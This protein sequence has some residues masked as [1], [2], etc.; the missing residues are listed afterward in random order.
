[1]ACQKVHKQGR[2][3][4]MKA[5]VNIKAMLHPYIF[6]TLQLDSMLET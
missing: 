4:S 2:D 6:L 3:D 5:K 1:M